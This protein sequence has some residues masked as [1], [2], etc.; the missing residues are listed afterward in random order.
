LSTP[1]RSSLH[2]PGDWRQGG[3]EAGTLGVMAELR[4]AG[5]A[6]CSVECHLLLIFH[7]SPCF[8]SLSSFVSTCP[9]QVSSLLQ[10][11]S[12][13]QDLPWGDLQ[14]LGWRVQVISVLHM[15]LPGH[16][17]EL[18]DGELRI[19]LGFISFVSLPLGERSLIVLS[20]PILCVTLLLT[21]EPHSPLVL[22]FP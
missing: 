22:Q 1:R 4:C 19:P 5:N 6:L 13:L 12:I 9:S 16:F 17:E 14:T 15:L 7:S 20:Y 10:N 18:Q 8:T 3:V 2:P 11:L 21:T